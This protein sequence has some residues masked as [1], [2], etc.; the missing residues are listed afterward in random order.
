VIRVL[1]II[2]SKVP[3]NISLFPCFFADA[4]RSPIEL[5]W[6]NSTVP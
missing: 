1:R 4:T 2:M 6:D 3:F 5:L